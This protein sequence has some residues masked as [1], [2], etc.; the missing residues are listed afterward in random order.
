MSDIVMVHYVSDDPVTVTL[1]DAVTNLPPKDDP[2]RTE[3]V[4]ANAEKPAV[5]LTGKLF[6][7][8]NGKRDAKPQASVTISLGAWLAHDP[9]GKALTSLTLKGDDVTGAIVA[10]GKRGRKPKGSASG[11]AIRALIASR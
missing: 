1:T 2:K 7:T 3:Y 8:E 5:R 11:D 4:K 9:K 10:Q 6:R